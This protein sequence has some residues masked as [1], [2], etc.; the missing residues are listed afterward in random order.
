[1][2]PKYLEFRNEKR[3]KE[4]KGVAEGHTGI[5]ITAVAPGTGT[6]G[7][8][9]PP[10]HHA[11]LPGFLG[12]TSVEESQSPGHLAPWTEFG[13]GVFPATPFAGITVSER[14]PGLV[15]FS[16][17]FPHTP[18]SGPQQPPVVFLQPQLMS[19]FL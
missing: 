2:E 15:S 6:Q 19:I 8:Q 9:P 3:L 16:G 1:M 13:L 4:A 12:F 14:K 11:R 18:R 10:F 5:F 7:S 17:S